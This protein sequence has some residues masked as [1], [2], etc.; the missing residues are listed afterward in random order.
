ML[1]FLKKMMG[2]LCQF[3][4]CN[5]PKAKECLNFKQQNNHYNSL[6]MQ[7]LQQHYQAQ[8]M[9]MINI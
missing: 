7:G 8:L 2:W 5:F 6:V 1:I 3:V 4:V 9:D